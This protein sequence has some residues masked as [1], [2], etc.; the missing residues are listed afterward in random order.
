MH[1]IHDKIDNKTFKKFW[2]HIFVLVMLFIYEEVIITCRMIIKTKYTD[3]SAHY[4]R[5]LEKV[6]WKTSRKIGRGRM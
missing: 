4:A 3:I 5:L 6:I 2:F 1:R